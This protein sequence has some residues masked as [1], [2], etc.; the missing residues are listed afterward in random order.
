MCLR[1]KELQ[2][3]DRQFARLSEAGREDLCIADH[4]RKVMAWLLVCALTFSDISWLPT[5][6]GWVV[7]IPN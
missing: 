1:S 3:C 7:N 4:E 2:N 6:C 5:H